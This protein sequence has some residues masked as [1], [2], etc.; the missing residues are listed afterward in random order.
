MPKCACRD[1][2]CNVSI[3]FD[4]ISHAMIVTDKIGN[5]VLIYVDEGLALKVI[6]EMKLIIQNINEINLL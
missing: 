2:K 5:D 4:S 1:P 6:E 3:S